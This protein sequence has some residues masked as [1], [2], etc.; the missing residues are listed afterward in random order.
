MYIMPVDL[1]DSEYIL[2]VCTQNDN[3]DFES[4]AYFKPKISQKT[5]N[6]LEIYRQNR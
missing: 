2:A 1:K 3:V 5:K 4:D 6:I